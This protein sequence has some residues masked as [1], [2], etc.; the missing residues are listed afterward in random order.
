MEIPSH[1]LPPVSL[2]A[3]TEAAAVINSTL[4]FDAVVSKIANLARSVT[5]AEAS[6][7]F[8][9]DSH[10]GKLVV[11]AATG[12]WREAMMD[13]EF[14]AGLGFPGQVVR[15]AEPISVVD[16]HAN[17]RFSRDI[18]EIS[19]TRTHSLMAAPMIHQ[20]HV[21]GVIEVVNRTDRIHFDEADLKILQVFASLAA[22]A[23]HNA[24]AHKDLKRRFDGLRDSVL[25]GTRIIGT[26]ARWQEVLGLCDRVSRSSATVL[27]LG[28]TGTG[29]EL[30]ARHIHN[31]SRRRE[32]SFVT[33]NCA[34]LP[35]TLLE[36]ELF[37]HEKGAFTGAHVQKRGWFEEAKG[38]TLFLDEIGEIGRP[39][40]AKL[41]RALQEKKIVRVGGTQTINCDVRVVAATNRNLKNQMIDGL[42]RED[43]YYR[44]SVFPIQL[45][46]LRDRREDIPLFIDQF[47]RSAAR[48]CNIPELQVASSTVETLSRYDWPGNV[49]ELQNVIERSVLMSDGDTLLPCHLPPDIDAAL[50]SEDASSEDPSTLYGQE[51]ALILKAL[52]ENNWNQSQ[53]AQAL[54]ITR[55]HVRHRIKKYSIKKPSR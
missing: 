29:K 13:R 27:L 10:S 53:A 2:T 21:I 26:S 52:E 41:L 34:A 5:H 39:M 16:A 46:A 25:A 19:G 36:S 35:E 31:G 42:F 3:L 7:V 20:S 11:V 44:L 40:Q 6:T 55:Y 54:G 17:A 37:G 22:T 24:R 1:S 43:L 15:A 30:I 32:E 18:D 8:T 14:D 47:V 4:D 50:V 49:R 12:H 9:L 38:G 45:P 48:D 51:R 23:A 28:E 33:V